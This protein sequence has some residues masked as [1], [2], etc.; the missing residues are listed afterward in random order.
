MVDSDIKKLQD[1]IIQFSE[2]REWAQFHNGKDLAL[3]LS[4]EASELNEAFLWKDAE[5]VSKEKIKEELADVFN[6]AFL[7]ASKYDLNVYDIVVQKLKKNADKY[8]VE[9]SRGNAKKYSEL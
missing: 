5:M 7:M 3:A 9:K 8:P 2:E 4:I 1:K 6:Y